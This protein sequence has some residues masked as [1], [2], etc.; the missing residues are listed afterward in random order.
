MEEPGSNMWSAVIDARK[1]HGKAKSSYGGVLRFLVRMPQKND[2]FHGMRPMSSG[3]IWFQIYTP[4]A[5]AA[6]CMHRER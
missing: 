4:K 1:Q 6:L 2:Y 5:T 3:R